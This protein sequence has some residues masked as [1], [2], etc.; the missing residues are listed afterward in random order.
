VEGDGAADAGADAKGRD[1]GDD[2]APPVEA[3][4]RGALPG[5]SGTVATEE[6]AV[7][8]AR[9]CADVVGDAAT[10]A[11]AAGATA[12]AF[13]SAE[14]AGAGRSVGAALVQPTAA[15]TDSMSH[16]NETALVARFMTKAYPSGSSRAA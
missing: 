11:V 9:P 16:A 12:A 1:G 5:A 8:G 4:G 10:S 7:G 15:P 14:A 13:V 3:P 6:A 2:D